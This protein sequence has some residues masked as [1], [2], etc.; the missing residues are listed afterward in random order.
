ML[1][2]ASQPDI[3]ESCLPG[4]EH[5]TVEPD[6]R[7]KLLAFGGERISAF[8]IILW[9]VSRLIG[10]ALTIPCLYLSYSYCIYI[11]VFIF[12]YLFIY[13]CLFRAAPTAYGG[14]QARGLIGAVVAGL[15]HSCSNMGSELHLLPTPQLTAM[16]DPKPME[17]GQDRSCNLMVPSRIHFCCAIMGTPVLYMFSYGKYF[18][19]GSRY[20]QM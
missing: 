7:L 20:S 15:Y 6:I 16:P 10:C 8:V 2:L 3:L 19:L 11:Y 4:T 13:F 17:Q 1:L 5:W 12:I 9:F 18:L 14:S